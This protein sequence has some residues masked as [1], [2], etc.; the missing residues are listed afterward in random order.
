M[1]ACDVG[2]IIS[3]SGMT[4][5]MVEC[6]EIM[7]NANVPVIAVTCFHESPTVKISNLNLY[8]T[9]TNLNFGQVSWAPVLRS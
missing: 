2:I 1:T 5:E 6:A 8:I 3:Y 4:P 7:K 9:A